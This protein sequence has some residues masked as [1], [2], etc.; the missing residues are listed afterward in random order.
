M[1]SRRVRVVFDQN[2]TNN[3][4]A[5]LGR[6]KSVGHRRVRR[7]QQEELGDSR[8][9]L[10][11]SFDMHDLCRATRK[12]ASGYVRMLRTW[13]L[14]QATGVSCCSLGILDSTTPTC[15]RSEQLVAA[16]LP[17]MLLSSVL[18]HPRCPMSYRAKQML[19][20]STTCST[21]NFP[22]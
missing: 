13:T 6:R 1:P 22:S 2:V 5:A 10:L 19:W 20:S 14:K 3:T 17:I 9:S 7:I 16:L 18:N 12:T 4:N 15:Q 11:T 21:A 8:R